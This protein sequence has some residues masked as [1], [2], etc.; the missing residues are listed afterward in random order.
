MALELFVDAG[1]LRETKP[2]LACLTGRLLDEGTHARSAEEL[3]EAIEDVGGTLDVGAC[4]ASLR[5]RAEDLAL[6][7]ELL[8][9]V[10]RRPAFPAEA[11]PWAKR[12]IVAELH[13]DRDDPAFRADL[14]FR[15]LVYG[16]HPYSRDP[17]GTTRDIARLTLDDV[18]AHHA[19]PL[20]ARQLVPGRRGGFRAEGPARPDPF[21][22]P[23]LEAARGEAV[24]PAAGRPVGAPRVRRVGHPGEQ[25]HIVLGHLGISRDHPD[26]DAL[27]VLDHIFGSGPGFTDRLS[28]I[29][30]DEL[31]LAYSVGGGMTD[32]ADVAPG[33]SASTSARCPT[34]P[35]APSPRSSSRCAPM[36][37]GDFSDEEVDRARRYLA[38]SWVYDYQTVEQRADRLMELE[39]WQ[40]SL[41]QPLRWPE[42]IAKVTPRQ[43][44]RAARAHLDPSALIRVEFGPIRRRGLSNSAEC[45]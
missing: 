28:R 16:D 21:E 29:L 33:C 42:R 17:R 31:G 30:R 8:A 39:R 3:A 24:A 26:L 41:D 14:I 1:L 22:V 6:A 44:R 9:D 11:I 20:H 12:R 10:A 38:G 36:H 15:G 7:V 2:G 37:A 19:A 43:V 18:K 13:G 23:D 27:A 35:T 40:L 32:S 34:R 4:G 5:V 45:A 25:V